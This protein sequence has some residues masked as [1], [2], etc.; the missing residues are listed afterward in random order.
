MPVDVRT[1]VG[2]EAFG[3]LL[4]AVRACVDA[5]ESRESSAQHGAVRVWVG[6]HGLATLRA[7]LPWFP[8]PTPGRPAR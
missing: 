8:W 7:S 3:F 1:M 4:E 2:A 6:L 5:G